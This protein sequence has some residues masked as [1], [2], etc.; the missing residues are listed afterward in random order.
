MY[1]AKVEGSTVTQVVVGD[2][3]W[4]SS[5]LGGVWLPSDTLVGIGWT[6]TDGTFT[7]PPT[8]EIDKLEDTFE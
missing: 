3:G 1:A 7:P 8:P 4:A 2:S 6:Y 5:R